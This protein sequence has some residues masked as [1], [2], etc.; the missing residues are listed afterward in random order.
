MTKAPILYLL[1]TP[2]IIWCWGDKI[3]PLIAQKWVKLNVTWFLFSEWEKKYKEAQAAIETEKV[4][5]KCHYGFTF[6]ESARNIF[7]AI[8][9]YHCEN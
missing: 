9:Q 8:G 6:T 3:E 5:L 4:T 7:S 2:E 1:K